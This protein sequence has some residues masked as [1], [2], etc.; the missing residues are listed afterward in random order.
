[1]GQ[2]ADLIAAE[3]FPF[4]WRV[5]V[6][7]TALRLI[8]RPRWSFQLLDTLEEWS[9]HEKAQPERIGAGIQLLAALTS[10]LSD[11]LRWS[12]QV[13][14]LKP[15]LRAGLKHEDDTVRM[16]TNEVVENLLRHGF[17][18]LLDLETDRGE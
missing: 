2:F 7:T 6:A 8:T 10:K 4:E 5:E 16:K 12:I 11:E 13:K 3:C 14:R 9:E 15:V 17:F 18:E 1:M